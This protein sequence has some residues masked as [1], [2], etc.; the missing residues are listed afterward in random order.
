MFPGGPYNECWSPYNDLL[1]AGLSVKDFTCYHICQEPGYAPEC[2]KDLLP[3][4][5]YAIPEAQPCWKGQEGQRMSDSTGE[6]APS[7]WLALQFTNCTVSDLQTNP[8]PHQ[9]KSEHDSR[10][11]TASAEGNKNNL[12]SFTGSLNISSKRVRNISG[13]KQSSQ[14]WPSRVLF[15]SCGPERNRG[16]Q[17]HVMINNYNQEMWLILYQLQIAFIV[18]FTN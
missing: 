4:F 6:A 12:N 11:L 14:R 16:P 3:G 5:Y 18:N 2:K 1:F 17:T 8:C 15:S 10:R 7:L 9:T 13:C